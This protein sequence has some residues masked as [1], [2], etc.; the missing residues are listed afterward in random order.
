MEVVQAVQNLIRD[1]FAASRIRKQLKQK[2]LPD[3]Q[4]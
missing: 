4:I 1:R 3:S 2:L